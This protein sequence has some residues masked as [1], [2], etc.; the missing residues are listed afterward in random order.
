[1]L[2]QAGFNAENPLRFTVLYSNDATIKKIVIA[3][4]AMWKKNLGVEARL[5]SQERKVTLD[6]INRGQYGVAYPLAG[7]RTITIRS[8]SWNVFRSDSSE[9]SAKYRNPD[10]DRI[11]HQATAAQTPQQVQQYFQQA[12]AVLAADTPVAPVYYEANATL[13]KP[14]VKGIDLTFRQGALYDKNVYLRKH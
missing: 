10:Y 11:L 6:N 5:Q 8:L 2:A 13:I 9:N 3:A 14:Y 1:M 4:A 12:E 7:W